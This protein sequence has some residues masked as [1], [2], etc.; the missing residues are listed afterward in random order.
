[1]RDRAVELT[2]LRWSKI[3]KWMFDLGDKLKIVAPDLKLAPSKSPV[4]SF[5]TLS[6]KA[7]REMK[8]FKVTKLARTPLF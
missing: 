6:A 7:F 5:N 4:V 1:M 2:G 8:I 3:Y